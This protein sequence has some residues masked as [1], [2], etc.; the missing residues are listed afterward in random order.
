MLARRVAACVT[1]GLI[2]RF[3]ADVANSFIAIQCNVNKSS[4][5]RRP[6]LLS[7]LRGEWTTVQT[8]RLGRHLESGR[9]DGST[10]GFHAT[11]SWYTHSAGLQFVH[12]IIPLVRLT[13]EICTFIF[14]PSVLP[15]TLNRWNDTH[16]SLPG[17][18]AA[19]AAAAD[20]D[21]YGDDDD[22]MKTTARLLRSFPRR[23]YENP[24][25]RKV[26]YNVLNSFFA[27]SNRLWRRRIKI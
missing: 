13:W 1:V 17:N 23:I 22:D 19:A 2:D 16:S 14:T 8:E 26:S 24:S 27:V 20:D 9:N 21:D 4:F 18:A 12:C 15:V 6:L 7:W 25:K 3:A 10:R 11:G 5:D